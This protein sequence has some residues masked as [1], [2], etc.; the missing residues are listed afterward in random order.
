[1]NVLKLFVRAPALNAF[2]AA[3]QT[4]RPE[5]WSFYTEGSPVR[6]NNP[7]LPPIRLARGIH[8]DFWCQGQQPRISLEKNR[9]RVEVLFNAK[10]YGTP[11]MQEIAAWTATVTA[12]GAWGSYT[13]NVNVS[14]PA[15][16]YPLVVSDVEFKPTLGAP[17]DDVLEWALPLILT[18]ALSASLLP[19]QTAIGEAGVLVA[20]DR[21][22][23]GKDAITI[24]GHVK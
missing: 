16:G 22:S 12:K 8:L 17:F 3:M 19:S 6:F 9:L 15:K 18:D 24:G 10:F 4:A 20:F 13:E 2:S 21:P 1:V 5:T 23:I 14:P 11:G 7:P